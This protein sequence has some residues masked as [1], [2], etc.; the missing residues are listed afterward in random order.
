M[1]KERKYNELTALKG[2]IRE[3]KSNYQELADHLGIAVNTLHNKINGY[4]E[5]KTAEVSKIVKYYNIPPEEINRYFF[6][7]LLRN[8]NKEV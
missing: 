8:E 3:E 7:D 1:P 5:F 2:K 4:T 6:P